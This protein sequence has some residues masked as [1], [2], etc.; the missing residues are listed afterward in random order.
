MSGGQS[1]Q[2]G[3]KRSGHMGGGQNGQKLTIGFRG[4]KTRCIIGVH[5]AERQQE[6]VV[7][8]DLEILVDL[9][10]ADTIDNTVDYS[11]LA[12]LFSAHARAGRFFL[13][14]SLAH[15]FQALLMERFPAIYAGK[16]ELRKPAALPEADHALARLEWY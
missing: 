4:L 3:H 8:S 6:Q 11:A 16:I 12:E 14:E 13:L 9:P 7:E 1:G 5:E 15:T 10:A 2:D